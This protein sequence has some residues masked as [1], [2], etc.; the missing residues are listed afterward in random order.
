VSNGIRSLLERRQG[1]P[2]FQSR[3]Y[4]AL[5]Y[6][7]TSVIKV[8]MDP[9]ECDSKNAAKLRPRVLAAMSVVRNHLKR[10]RGSEAKLRAPAFVTVR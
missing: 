6:A 1:R 2:G 4:T 9:Q 8:E 10:E 3:H 5:W 7:S